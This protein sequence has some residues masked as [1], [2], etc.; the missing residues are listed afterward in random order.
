MPVV[1]D[2]S[3]RWYPVRM[4]KNI[5]ILSLTSGLVFSCG[6]KDEAKKP[7]ESPKNTEASKDIEPAGAPVVAAQPAATVLVI[8]AAKLSF[9][10]DKRNIDDLEAVELDGEGNV[11]VKGEAL[12]KLAADGTVTDKA[13]TVIA[14]IAVDGKVT[15]EGEDETMIIA[16]DGTITADDGEPAVTIGEDG[17]VAMPELMSGVKMVFEGP[18]EARRAMMLAYMTASKPAPSEPMPTATDKTIAPAKAK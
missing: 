17:V 3:H 15:L 2:E 10:S 1:E 5:L 18:K 13:G 7:D 8:K 16:E 4:F 6:K 9:E 11:I 14:S 12:L